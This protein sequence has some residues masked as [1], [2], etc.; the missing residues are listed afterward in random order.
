[1]R[2]RKFSEFK[3]AQVMPLIG[4][5]KFIEW[6]I[7]APPRQPSDVLTGV[8]GW[9]RSFDT[10]GTE[11]AKLLLM[12][13]LVGEVVSEY[14]QLKVWKGEALESATLTGFA[15]YLFTPPYAY[16]KTPLLCAAEAKKDD[17]DNGRAQ[18]LAE[19]VAC[20]EKNAADGYA[21]DLFGFVSNGQTWIF[22][23]LTTTDEIYETL[24]YGL[25]DLPGLLGALDYI[26]AECAKRVPQDSI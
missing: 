8:F 26:C 15:D 7:A 11:A 21:L 18:C 23:K 2:K 9:L 5:A 14:K 24:E 22:Y 10:K 17:F 13:A 3:L 1:M 25:N 6:Q 16:M 19:M 20:R 4:T 12:D